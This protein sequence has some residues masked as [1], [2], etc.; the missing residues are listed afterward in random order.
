VSLIHFISLTFNN[1]T[2][3]KHEDLVKLYL[4]LKNAQS[5]F[6]L[7]EDTEDLQAMI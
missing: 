1:V 3:K 6:K 4:T 5:G 7:P 2:V